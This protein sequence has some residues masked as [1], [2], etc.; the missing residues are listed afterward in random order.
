[1]EGQPVAGRAKE[2]R[3]NLQALMPS[4]LA[5]K[6]S[7][8]AGEIMGEHREVTV[9]YVSVSRAAGQFTLDNEDSYFLM[10]VALRLLTEVVY[11]YEGTIDKFTGD[12]LVALFGAP[13]AHEND[14]E[15]AIRATLEMQTAFEPWQQQVN[16]KYGFDFQL[17]IGINSGAVIAG[18]VGSD[19][20][21]D[22]TVIG[23]TV[24]LAYHLQLAAEPGFI[25][26]SRDTY[27][28]TRTLFEFT[29]L[30]PLTI[31]WLPQ[32]IQAYRPLT[33]RLQ[34]QPPGFQPPLIGR[35]HALAHMEKALAN[36]INGHRLGVI[37][38]TG[39]AGLGKSRLA[40]EFR[41]AVL[42][43][44]AQVYQGH[45]LTYARSTPLY[46][47]AS[48]VRHTLSLPETTPDELQ[49]EAL[50]SRLQH[51]N[52]PDTDLTPYL[53]H[54]LGLLPAAPE[55]E[56]RIRLLDEA[57]LLR[58]THA[59]LRRLLLAQAEHGPA[60]I[61]LEDL[62]WIDSAS[63]EFLKYFFQTTPH[64]PLLVLLI[65]RP[66]GGD[67]TLLR[68][69]IDSAAGEPGRFIDL[70][71]SPLNA[72]EGQLMADHLIP[73]TS[74]R[75]WALKR[76]IVARAEGNPFFVQEILRMLI[77]QGGLIRSADTGAWE[78]TP[79]AN[80][81]LKQ[82]PGSV[83]GLILAR[84]DRLPENSRQALQKAAV[85]GPKFTAPMLRQLLNLPPEAPAP[86]LDILLA[87]EFLIV[88]SFRGQPG[89]KFQH[90]LLQ[91][92]VYSTLLNRDRAKIHGRI[93]Q[94]IENSPLWLA[95][96]RVE[97]LAYHY[98]QSDAPA[99]A[100]PYL[101]TAADKAAQRCAYETAIDR[102]RQAAALTASSPEEADQT[103]LRVRLGLGRA[104]KFTGNFTEAAQIFTDVLETFPLS[105]QPVPAPSQ[106]ETLRQ[107]A[108]TRQREGQFDEALTYLE[109]GL[110]SL[111]GHRTTET[112]RL[113]QAILDRMAWI[114]FRQ[115]K[116]DDAR[117]LA[118]EASGDE[119]INGHDPMRL[120]SLYNTLGGI[121]WQQGHLSQAVTYVEHSLQLY[122]QTGYLWGTAIA[123]G[124]LGVLYNCLGNWLRAVE[125]HE[126]AQA[127]QQ[128][129]G[130]PEGLAVS[131]DNLGL[132]H[133]SMGHHTQAGQDLAQGLALRTRLGDMWGMAQSH[134]NLAYLALVEGHLDTANQHVSQALP[135]ADKIGS[136]EIRAQAR[137]VLALVQAEQAQWPAALET[138]TQ[139]LE[140]AR[141]AG[142]Q[143]KEIECLRVLGTL[144]THQGQFDQAEPLLRRSQELA[145]AQNDPYLQG[146][147]LFELGRLYRQQSA[148]HPVEAEAWQTKAAAA[149]RQAAALFQALG[150]AHDLNLARQA[151]SFAQK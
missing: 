139:A 82:T 84:F 11:T 66:T 68:P 130:N 9:V 59:A 70:P 40:D 80:D 134:S 101:L 61:I 145:V 43:A 125:C 69:L 53:A 37:L 114:R 35:G 123:Y 141:S 47:I 100:L 73:Q 129:I 102:Y 118:L 86:H 147:A 113:W 109:S 67:P 149:L 15:R 48:L 85:L 29:V 27:R 89:Y 138:A 63:L 144:H 31:Q 104:L 49:I 51:L 10:E 146:Q 127:V 81:L 30:P 151:L 24:N 65:S 133:M 112:N 83:K 62:H 142:L 72:A 137:W 119:S 18:K 111:N 140:I 98:T 132:L 39:E 93:A 150:A 71:L 122:E 1:V 6:I 14:P 95:E 21:M 28:R 135:L 76:H 26:V 56:N 13:V 44:Q 106:I 12:G 92:T 64:A 78:V 126:Q 20:H 57:M 54:V 79:P 33:L 107:L 97:L 22:Y 55:L 8:S 32:P 60:V 124:N 23:E 94:I 99:R 17:R 121:A 19:L 7:A 36:V 5:Q 2:V 105:S 136:A 117:R 90:A 46:V 25:L 4:T 58:Q 143:E 103:Y 45:C 120:A 41:Q 108:D 148:A 16:Q 91:E 75:A 52:L 131:L 50:R 88:T 34:P 74:A 115:G 42:P 38:L 116:L 87:R 77:D 128:I 110:R 3:Q 96:E